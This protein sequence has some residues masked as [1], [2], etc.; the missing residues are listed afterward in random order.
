MRSWHRWA[1][2]GGVLLATVGC[3]QGTKQ[4]AVATLKNEPTRSFLGD[5]FRLGYAENPGAFLGLGGGMGSTL[6][7]WVFSVGVGVLLLG[8]LAYLFASQTLTFTA[9]LGL[10]LLAGGGI[11]NWFDR[12]ANDGRVV[13]FLNLGIGS[14]RTGIF[15]V[16]DVAI[17]AGAA[18]MIFGS[19]PEKSAA[20]PTQ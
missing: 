18:I 17:M 19:R 10:S 14:V 1:V 15:N 3:D 9:S 16:A 12:V 7:F 6:Q 13:D 2:A 4:L 5:L 8:M 20:Q 11:S